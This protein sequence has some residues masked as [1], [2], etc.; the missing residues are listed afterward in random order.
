[1]RM[2]YIPGVLQ[3]DG[4]VLYFAFPSEVKREDDVRVLK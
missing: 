1:M 3:H 4:T 2:L